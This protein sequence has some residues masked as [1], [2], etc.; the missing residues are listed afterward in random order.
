MPT[1]F[2][3]FSI[4]NITFRFSSQHYNYCVWGINW[5]AIGAQCG[6]H[7][8]S[9]FEY[10]TIEHK[11]V[12]FPVRYT[13][14]RALLEQPAKLAD[15]IATIQMPETFI[16]TVSNHNERVVKAY[17]ECRVRVVCAEN[18]LS[19]KATNKCRKYMALLL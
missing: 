15:A 10:I 16:H 6:Q 14:L 9:T 7:F 11:Q 3:S 8:G 2:V 5:G 13:F 17:D 12:V 4:E 1:F 18:Y 19:L